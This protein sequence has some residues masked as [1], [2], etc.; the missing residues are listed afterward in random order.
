MGA[1]HGVRGTHPPHSPRPR[2]LPL[3][4]RHLP[5][6]RHLPSTSPSQSSRC[7]APTSSRLTI[8]PAECTASRPRAFVVGGAVGDPGGRALR[9]RRRVRRIDRRERRLR[10][11]ALLP[12]HRAL[13]AL[14][15]SGGPRQTSPERWTGTSS[16]STGEARATCYR[17]CS[18][19]YPITSAGSRSCWAS[20]RAACQRASVRAVWVSQTR[21]STRAGRGRAGTSGA[22][23]WTTA[24]VAHGIGA[25]VPRMA[26]K[27]SLGEKAS[28]KR[29]KAGKI[30]EDVTGKPG[31]R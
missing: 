25:G 12:S 15:P 11:R 29:A 23:W 30:V 7:A 21:A 28:E 2:H 20:A 5:R 24:P 8:S 4:P 9:K 27:S 6:P 3:C 22:E 19:S 17:E 16:T 14:V 10:P 1:T 18:R 31:T 26:K 13:A